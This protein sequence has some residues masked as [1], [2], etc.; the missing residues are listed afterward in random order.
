MK[1][2]NPDLWVLV[3][4]WNT[5]AAVEDRVVKVFASWY[6]GYANGDS[7][8]LS[9]G[10]TGVRIDGEFIEFDNYSGS[11]YRA[12]VNNWGASGFGSSVLNSFVEEMKDAPNGNAFRVFTE[13]EARG[14]IAKMIK[15]NE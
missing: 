14:Y 2:Y 9:S 15:V 4:M 11:V 3:E 8:K 6:G 1:T 5:Q 10:V 13:E 12:Y 7:W